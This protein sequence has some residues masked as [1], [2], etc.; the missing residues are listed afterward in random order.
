MPSAAAAAAATAVTYTTIPIS[1][2]DVIH[3]SI[4]NLRA[5]LSSGCRSCREF[6]PTA[7]P[8]DFPRSL[9]DVSVRFR[10][11]YGYFSV[12]YAVIVAACAAASLIASPI[13]LILFGSISSL[14]LVLYFFREDPIFV[15]GRHVSDWIVFLVLVAASALALLFSGPIAGLTIGIGVG[16]LVSAVHIL[17]RNTE[18]SFLDENDAV[19]SGLIAANPNSVSV[20]R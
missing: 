7:S 17:L 16:I 3:R 18:D 10:R 2:S 9:P 8:V 5:A 19:S 4:Q 11:N 15:W 20:R 14:W 6:L 12:N 13:Q 1:V